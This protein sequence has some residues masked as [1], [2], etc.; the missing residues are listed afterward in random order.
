MAVAILGISLAFRIYS[1]VAALL[2]LGEGIGSYAF[3]LGR[4]AV[5]M[6]FYAFQAFLLFKILHCRNW[7]RVT[8]SIIVALNV[9][10]ASLLLMSPVG[11]IVF[12]PVVVA[13]QAMFEVAAIVILF[14]SKQFVGVSERAA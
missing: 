3:Q 2:D 12:A 11:E 5:P 8:M 6:A 10:L 4:T 1:E 13:G 7:A 14:A 9:L